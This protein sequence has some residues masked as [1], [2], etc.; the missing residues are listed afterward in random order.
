MT[1]ITLPKSNQCEIWKKEKEII[2]I[3]VTKN[4]TYQEAR[5]LFELIPKPVYSKIVQSSFVK[6]STKTTSTQYDKNDF[7]KEL[8]S[9]S[10]Q[11]SSFS[12]QTITRSSQSSSQSSQSTIQPSQSSK[13]SQPNSQCSSRSPQPNTQSP[14]GQSRPGQQRTHSNNKEESDRS[15]SNQSSRT[16]KEQDKH[17]SN[18][19]KK[20]SHDPI[21][22]ANSYESLEDMELDLEPP[23]KNKIR[24]FPIVLEQRFFNIL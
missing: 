9:Q 2:K 21:K 19:Q 18:R 6:P 22:L 11:S 7:L 14:R 8:N 5:K 12:S 23:L 20:G 10:S 1:K 17:L 24:L 13:S 15:E 16:K 4:I 3:K